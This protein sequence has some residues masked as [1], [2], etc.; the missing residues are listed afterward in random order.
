MMNKIEISG[1]VRD[2]EIKPNYVTFILERKNYNLYCIARDLKD[3]FLKYV[4][5]GDEIIVEG[6]FNIFKSV[7]SELLPT[8][9]IYDFNFSLF[10][11]GLTK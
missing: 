11:A 3:I 1:I 9:V 2:I 6:E 5:I 4:K 10:N 8:I 7:K